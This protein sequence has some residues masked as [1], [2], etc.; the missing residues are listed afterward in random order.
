MKTALL[1]DDSPTILLS[2]SGVLTKAGYTVHTAPAGDAALAKLAGGLTPS[3]MITDLNMPGMDGI[4]L[5][6]QARLAPGCRFVPMLMLTTESRSDRRA[7]AKAAGAT[8]WLV[9]PVQAA[10]LVS[11]LERVVKA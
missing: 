2:I 7:E 8:G 11:V 4:E 1:V 6:R 3:V 9:K 10:D 5:I